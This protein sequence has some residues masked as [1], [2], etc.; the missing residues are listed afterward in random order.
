MAY[1]S[2]QTP[3]SP[4]VGRRRA[5]TRARTAGA[6][7]VAAADRSDTLRDGKQCPD[8]SARFGIDAKFCPFDG[9]ALR[10]ITFRA[11]V[12]PLVGVVVDGRYEVV[13]HIGA[14]GMGTVYK[15][16]HVSID[17]LFA[18]K[19][20]RPEHADDRELIERF[21][22]E[23]RAAARARHPNIVEIMDFGRLPTG[24]PY[25]VMELLHGVDLHAHQKDHKRLSASDVVSIAKAVG[26]ALAAAHG[27]GVVHRDLKPENIFL[28]G[29]LRPLDDVRV[30]DFG[31]AKIM[32][33]SKLTRPGIVFG[34]PYYMAPEQANG[35]RTDHRVDV[36]ALGVVMYEMLTGTVPFDGE[37]YLAIIAKHIGQDPQPPSQRAPDADIPPALE[38]VVLKALA[39]RAED[40]FAHMDALLAALDEAVPDSLPELPAPKPRASTPAIFSQMSTADRIEL[41]VTREIAEQARDGRRRRSVALVAGLGA[42]LG[43]IVVAAALRV[44]LARSPDAEARTM[45]DR[46]VSPATSAPGASPATPLPS[47]PPAVEPA[48]AS[49]SSAAEAS[50]PTVPVAP[51]TTAPEASR[52]P[53]T[54]RTAGLAGAAPRAASSPSKAAPAAPTKAKPPASQPAPAPPPPKRR[55]GVDDFADPWK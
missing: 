12:D 36:Y 16:R 22:R 40:R 46:G 43:V 34:T 38:A 9:S 3:R 44:W 53:T 50:I 24:A 27:A 42:L 6:R 48:P 31:A 13:A 55:S 33:G 21:E 37:S 19:S 41:S 32:G 1:A 52:A 5:S 14:G 30:V 51:G 10:A 20:L 49:A 4:K 23:A 15:V 54:S 11:G 26:D 18:L 7:T 25:Y 17:R 28:C 39:K 8:C 45:V 35:L 29:K 47:A 2:T